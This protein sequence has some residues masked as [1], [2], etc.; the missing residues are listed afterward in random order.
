MKLEHQLR[1]IAVLGFVLEHAD[2]PEGK[3]KIKR[4]MNEVLMDMFAEL[5]VESGSAVLLEGME[6]AL[7]EAAAEVKAE[8]GDGFT[9]D[10]VVVDEKS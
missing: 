7:E 8:D 6:K 9:H 1:I 2:V 3:E 4:E 5:V 10:A